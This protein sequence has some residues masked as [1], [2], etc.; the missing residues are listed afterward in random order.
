MPFVP[1]A[2]APAG[3]RAPRGRTPNCSRGL[4]P[5][6]GAS[7]RKPGVRGEGRF[8]RPSRDAPEERLVPWIAVRASAPAPGPESNRTRGR[9]A[10]PIAKPPARAPARARDQGRGAHRTTLLAEAPERS[11]S[12][13]DVQTQLVKEEHPGHHLDA[14][15]RRSARGSDSLHGASLASTASFGRRRRSLPA[16][17]RIKRPLAHGE[18]GHGR[19]LR[20]TATLEP[21]T[22]EG[23]EHA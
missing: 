3:V 21:R 2:D 4:G 14:A 17:C 23:A 6:S 13:E 5:S 8:S 15:R 11:A 20:R 19:V 10:A 18:R 9:C 12:I 7:T 16:T 22:A 1:I